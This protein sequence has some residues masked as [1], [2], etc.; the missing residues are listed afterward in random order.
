MAD[1][2]SLLSDAEKNYQVTLKIA[3]MWLRAAERELREAAE[4]LARGE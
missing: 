1:A 3:A 4:R 2:G